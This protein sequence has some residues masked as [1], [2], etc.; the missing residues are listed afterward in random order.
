MNPRCLDRLFTYMA[1]INISLFNAIVSG[2]PNG[3]GETSGRG[4]VIPIGWRH[5]QGQQVPQRIHRHMQ[6]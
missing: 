1:Q 5:M 2:H 3:G 6:L 4:A